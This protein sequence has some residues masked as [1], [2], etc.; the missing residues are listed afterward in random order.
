MKIFNLTDD[1]ELGKVGAD[2]VLDLGVLPKGT[3][4]T[5]RLRFTEVSAKDIS[6]KITCGCT[7]ISN[8]IVVDENTIEIYISVV[9]SGIYVKTAEIKMNGKITLLK[10][11]GEFK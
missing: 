6:F 5:K 11:K 4:N 8:K 7:K 2:F 3:D 1:Y 10:L 9:T